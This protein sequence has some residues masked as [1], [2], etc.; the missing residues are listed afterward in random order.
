MPVDGPAKVLRRRRGGPTGRLSRPAG[1]QEGADDA[2][3]LVL[4]FG[5]LRTCPYR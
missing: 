2:P 4:A 5:A 1:V 3:R